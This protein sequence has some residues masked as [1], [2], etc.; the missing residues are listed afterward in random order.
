MLV[1]VI[2]ANNAS[3]NAAGKYFYLNNDLNFGAATM[4]PV[5]ATTNGFKATLYGGRH[6]ISNVTFT[7]KNFNSRNQTG[8]FGG[9]VSAQI[10]DLGFASNCKLTTSSYLLAAGMLAAASDNNAVIVNCT[11]VANISL[12]SSAAN[13]AG[14]SQGAIMIGGLIGNGGG[15]FYK[16]MYTG[17]ITLTDTNAQANA[18]CAM[19]DQNWIG[20]LVACGVTKAYACYVNINTIFYGGGCNS[21]AINA[22]G[23]TTTAEDCVIVNFTGL[24]G[25]VTSPDSVSIGDFASPWKI[26]NCYV[27]SN[28]PIYTANTS[29]TF[30]NVYVTYGTL[31]AGGGGYSSGSGMGTIPAGVTVTSNSAANAKVVMDKAKS[32]S[33]VSALFAIT[34]STG[35]NSGLSNVSDK[36]QP[37]GT[38]GSNIY[39][40]FFAKGLGASGGPSNTT[41][42]YSSS[43]RNVNTSAPTRTG[44]TFKGWSITSP[45]GAISGTTSYLTVP[46]GRHSDVTAYAVW[47]LNAFSGTSPSG[48]TVTYGSNA[49]LSASA[50]THPA[51][52]SNANYGVTLSYQPLRG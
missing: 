27:T 32:N 19:N 28:V 2:N 42:V 45:S 21:G 35:N 17:T 46:A 50:L 16:C 39:N 37:G 48:A 25:N 20:G 1:N 8:C 18:S 13:T 11:N 44:Y 24:N 4:D 23:G 22:R 29:S 31:N 14:T 49:T 12:A 40:I 26:S 33:T 15:T 7:N 9:L 30:S 3:Y 6:T 10:Y 47:E 41:F 38:S 34:T 5:G 36:I 52:T 51:G 43:A